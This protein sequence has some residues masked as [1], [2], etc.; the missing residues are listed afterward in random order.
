MVI[1]DENK[2]SAAALRYWFRI[3]DLQNTG[4]IGEPEI[5]AFYNSQV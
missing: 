3:L 2:R 4:R 5:H 1:A